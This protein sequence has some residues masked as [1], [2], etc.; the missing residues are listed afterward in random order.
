M[1]NERIYNDYWRDL[2][3]ENR[4]QI[5][6]QWAKTANRR[7]R[8]LREKN[9]LDSIGSASAKAYLDRIGRKTFYTKADKL[10]DVEVQSALVQ[11]Q[12][13][14]SDESTTL[15]G[16]KK[17][18][19]NAAGIVADNVLK[20]IME[21]DISE[22]KKN[23]Y[24]SVFNRVKNDP[25]FGIFLHSKLYSQLKGRIDSD[26]V[27]EYY[28]ERSVVEGDSFEEIME[29]F[30]EVLNNDI[31]YDTL[32]EIRNNSKTHEPRKVITKDPWNLVNRPR[33]SVVPNISRR[34]KSKKK[35]KKRK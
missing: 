25:Y 28:V 17:I 14:L 11:L 8:R 4:R 12:S 22:E 31:G 32:L 21:R 9:V 20:R 3:P 7:L 26:K 19:E 13:F 15:S 6:E 24:Q 29:A 10:S 30:E 33:Y 1:E 34:K 2:S 16:L 18:H 35:R 23:T 27:I 5:M